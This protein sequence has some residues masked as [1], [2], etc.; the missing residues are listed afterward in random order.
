MM[1]NREVDFGVLKVY[2]PQISLTIKRYLLANNICDELRKFYFRYNEHRLVSFIPK[3]F[4]HVE[5]G[6]AP[7]ASPVG[8]MYSK[9]N[10]GGHM[11]VS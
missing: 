10:A 8:A 4:Q 6:I 1:H 5:R 9:G 11:T 7:E 2:F 3:L